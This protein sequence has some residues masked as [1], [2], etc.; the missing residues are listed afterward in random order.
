V[1]PGEIEKWIKSRR[2]IILHSRRE[3]IKLIIT[4]VRLLP[5]YFSL[6][7]RRRTPRTRPVTTRIQQNL[8]SAPAHTTQL[9]SEHFTRILSTCTKSN[10][11]LANNYKFDPKSWEQQ[12]L[13]FG[14]FPT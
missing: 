12:P 4:D 8:S 11:P 3:A 7:P 10:R 6:L 9:L 2:P 14:D 13:Q 1:P 5:N